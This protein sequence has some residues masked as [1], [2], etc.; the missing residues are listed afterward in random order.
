MKTIKRLFNG[1]HALCLVILHVGAIGFAIAAC[2]SERADHYLL[3][4]IFCMVA[5]Q[6]QRGPE[7]EEE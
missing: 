5:L 4:A 6:R 1:I 7:E 3:W 2:V